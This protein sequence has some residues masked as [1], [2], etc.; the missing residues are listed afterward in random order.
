MIHFRTDGEFLRVGLNLCV[1]RNRITV[2]WV[3]YDFVRNEGSHRGFTL[4]RN[5]FRRRSARWNVID[6][7]L[8]ARNLSVVHDEVLQDL[9]EADAARRRNAESMSFIRPR[10]AA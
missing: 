2:H 1:T 5:G 6:E 9:Y 4:S 8:K 7:Y 10:N 3:W